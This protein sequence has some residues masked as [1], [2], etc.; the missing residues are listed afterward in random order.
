V[1]K[2]VILLILIV[3]VAWGPAVFAKTMYTSDV[4]EIS[5]RQG[6][7]TSYPIIKT[8]K[9]NEPVTV[10]ESSNGWS[11]I[12]LTDGKEGWLV[13][14]YLTDKTPGSA[15]SPE[16]EKKTDQMALQL[17]AAGEENE[18]LKKEIQSLK[19]QLDSNMKNI[20]DLRASTNPN[21]VESEEFLALKAKFDQI[22][23]ESKEKTHRINELQQQLADIGKNPSEYKCYLY[24]FLAGAGVL[25]LGM[26]IGSST[27]R[28]RSSLL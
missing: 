13:S 10:L 14:S 24:L 5:V 16:T 7:D 26:I 21:P 4:T 8:L 6:R 12:Q 2:K 25:L 18:R 27:K 23:T 11:K 19:S 22:S 3:L 17:K 20:G 9:S 1:I 15:T 28:R